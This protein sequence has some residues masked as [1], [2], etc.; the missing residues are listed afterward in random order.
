[1]RAAEWVLAALVVLLP[2][3]LSL[4][5]SS[6]CPMAKE[7]GSPVRARPPALAFGILWPLLFLGL[8]LALLRA[9]TKWPVLALVALLPLW[10]VLYVKS[11][12]DNRR[13]AAWLLIAC[14]AFGV[15]G[16][17]FA[18]VQRDRWSIV[19]L[20]ALLAWLVFAQQ[21]AMLDLQVASGNI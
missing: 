18:T 7:S 11:C 6:V 14:V 20:G 10:Q 19:A 4:V 17:C 13:A 15:I 9:D 3:G 8:G 16:L 5:A 21:L 2:S 12:G 1:M